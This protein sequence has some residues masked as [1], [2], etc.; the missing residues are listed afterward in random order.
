MKW[1]ETNIT[2]L[3]QT[4]VKYIKYIKYCM[5][6]GNFCQEGNGYRDTGYRSQYCL[7][8]ILSPGVGR[9]RQGDW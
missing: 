4:Q 6:G 1:V 9:C 5:G 8:K 3:N 2:K 7:G